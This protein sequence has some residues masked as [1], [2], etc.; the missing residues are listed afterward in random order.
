MHIRHTHIY[1]YIYLIWVISEKNPKIGKKNNTSIKL[2]HSTELSTHSG[3]LRYDRV[4]KGVIHLLRVDLRRPC[5]GQHYH[6]TP[7]EPRHETRHCVESWCWRGGGCSCY[8]GRSWVCLSSSRP[9]WSRTTRPVLWGDPCGDCL[10]QAPL[11]LKNHGNITSIK[12]WINSNMYYVRMIGYDIIF[13]KPNTVKLVFKGHVHITEKCP[14]MTGVPTWQ[15]SLHDRC[16]YMTGVP[17]WR[18]SLH[19]GCPYMT[20]VPTWQVSLHDRCPYMT[21]VPT[22]QVSLHDRCPYMTGVPSWQVS[23]HDRCPFVT[24]SLT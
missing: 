2:S 5:R 11:L 12:I 16:P 14:Y 8:C 23:L 10:P 1:W 20:G 21:G 6:R 24:G 19:D 22:W 13:W 17:T 3:W 18:V 9:C 7:G 15:V 4:S